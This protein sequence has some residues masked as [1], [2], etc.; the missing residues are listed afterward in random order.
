MYARPADRHG[1]AS[2]EPLSASDLTGR[3]LRRAGELLDIPAASVDPDAPLSDLGLTSLHAVALG[4]A[5]AEWTGRHVPTSVFWETPTLG[6]VVDRV[7]DRGR[8]VG[9]REPS[10]STAQAGPAAQEPVAIIGIGCRLPGA[11]TPEQLWELLLAGRTTAD[12]LELHTSDGTRARLEGSFLDDVDSFDAAFFGISPREAASM[13]PQQRLL[14][15]TAWEALEDAGEVPAALA[16]SATGVFVGVSG[17]DHGRL[18]FGTPDAD[19]HIG[20]GS[21]LSIAANRLSYAFHLTG[22]SMSVDTACSSSLVAVHLACRSLWEGESELALAA[23]VN[24][25]LDGAVGDAFARAGFLSPDGRCK[26]FDAAADGYGRGEGCAV[27]VLKPLSR[28]LADGDPVHAVIKST[29]VNQDGHSNGLTAPSG[30]AQED[31]LTAAYRRAG[32]VP[33]DVGYVEAHG[34]GTALGDPIEARAIGRALGRSR[35]AE[36]PLYVGSVK[37]NVGHL[38]AAAGITGLVKAALCVSHRTIPP[39]A[40]YRTPNPDIDFGDL[41][42]RVPDA[43]T[44]WPEG[45]DEAIAGV[46]SFGFGGTNAH[47]VLGEPPATAAPHVRADQEEHEPGG[48]LLLPVSGADPAD[49]GRQADGYRRLLAAD[50]ARLG[51][52]AHTAGTRRT[53]HR[54]RR[55]LVAGDTGEA[56]ALLAGVAAEP[57]DRPI[58]AGRPGPIAFVFSGQGNQWVGMGRELLRD[59][60]VAAAVL[61]ECDD[62][63]EKLT[64]WSLLERLTTDEEPAAGYDDPAVLQPVLVSVQLAVARLLES[65]GIAPRACVG[66]SLGEISAAAATGALSTEEALFLAVTRG[67]VMREATGT[68][69]TALLGLAADEVRARI[70]AVGGAVDIAA[71]NAPRSTLIAGD[72]PTVARLVQQAASDGAF[73][74]VLPGTTAFHS[75]FVEPLHDRLADQMRDLAPQDVGATLISTVTGHPVDGGALDGAYWGRNLREPVRFAQAVRHLADAGCRTFVEIGAHPTLTP[76]LLETAA[77]AG[78]EIIAVPTLRR[79]EPSRTALLYTAG[80]LYE[81]GTGID[82]AAVNHGAAGVLRLPVRQWNR[83]RFGDRA[84]LAAR[85]SQAVSAVPAGLLGRRL[86]PASGDVH[87]WEGTLAPHAPGLAA[88]QAGRYGLA[89]VPLHLPD[90]LATAALDATE[91]LFPGREFSVGVRPRPGAVRVAQDAGTQLA[92]LPDGGGARLTLHTRGERAAEWLPYAEATATEARP[93]PAAPQGAVEVAALLGRLPQHTHGAALRTTL[94]TSGWDLPEPERIDAV[95]HG[96]EGAL[97]RL[98]AT[99]RSRHAML[100]TAVLA[101]VVTAHLADRGPAAW[102]PA[103]LEGVFVPG[104][105]DQPAPVWAHVAPLDDQSTDAAEELALRVRLVDAE[106]RV[107]SEI[108]R[109]ALSPLTDAETAAAA[110]LL[111]Q[112]EAMLAVAGAPLDELLAASPEER[113]GL[114]TDY[115]RGET[116]RVLRAP[117]S[118]ID[119]AMPMNTLGLDSI[120]SLELHRRLEAALGIEVPVVR[121]LRGATTADIAAELATSLV[122]GPERPDDDTGTPRHAE[123]EDPRDIERLLAE[124][125]DLPE[126]E[127][128]S[129]LQRLAPQAAEQS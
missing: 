5:L 1:P 42:L 81:S 8:P 102:V 105:A 84:H 95:H 72:G 10:G 93:A 98:R 19:L 89:G 69:G 51:A 30:T 35:R 94:A 56:G 16:G 24:V 124:L 61:G 116:A 55:A 31:L 97:I 71:W 113:V 122:A 44:A 60:P 117:A 64:G 87:Y 83:Q 90:T 128:D 4:E 49:A 17:Y 36:Q 100:D 85:M 28:A 37:S 58:P 18:H 120:M 114:L 127:V 43:A 41:G 52:L 7:L 13:D 111:H 57:P 6:G 121:F 82:L 109:I 101:A 125:D 46:S 11:A 3:L 106:G 65:W 29:A 80:A 86:S 70:E 88:C 22:P 126:E 12:G 123:L 40:G 27:V 48:A 115:L 119:A 103:R 96:P 23:G 14:L 62:I 75:R 26:T 32:V 110:A 108:G 92:L 99:A 77:D 118:S 74:R 21:A 38:E 66:H 47:I 79:G 76:A 25:I 34:T 104:A 2:P 50:P 45:Y 39:T 63:L 112:D 59:E 129:L 54:F 91:V 67:E 33:D 73:A 9:R 20:T 68:G 53:Q 78:A 107:L 15:E